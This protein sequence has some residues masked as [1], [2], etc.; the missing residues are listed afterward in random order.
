MKLKKMLYKFNLGGNIPLQEQERKKEAAA[1]KQLATLN[2]VKILQKKKLQKLKKKLGANLTPEISAALSSQ[3]SILRI[4]ISAE[5]LLD[6]CL[7]S[8]V[9]QM[10]VPKQ[11]TLSIVE[12]LTELYGVLKQ[13]L[14][15]HD[16]KLR[17]KMIH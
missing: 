8:N 11:K 15:D 4:T 2:A 13:Y 5:K 1:Q 14:K 7:A 12:T 3:G 17:P 10:S 16:T 6:T 9:E